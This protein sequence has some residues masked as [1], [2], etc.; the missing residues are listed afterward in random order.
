MEDYSNFSI[1]FYAIVAAYAYVKM[2][3]EMPAKT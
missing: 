2:G 3:Y 1:S